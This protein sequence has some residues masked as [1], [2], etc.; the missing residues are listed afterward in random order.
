MKMYLLRHFKDD[1]SAHKDYRNLVFR[2]KKFKLEIPL[3]FWR[4]E[5]KCGYC[6]K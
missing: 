5:C 1:L 6:E 3:I 2:F 4:K